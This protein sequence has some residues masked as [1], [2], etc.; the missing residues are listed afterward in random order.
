MPLDA[1][2]AEDPSL[3]ERL[4]QEQDALVR[5]SDPQPVLNTD[6]RDFVEARLDVA[7]HD[8]LIRAGGKEVN[9]GD[10]VLHPASGT[11]AVTA[12]LEIRLQ[13]RLKHRLEGSLHDPVT[14]G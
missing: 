5:D 13:D 10:R 14:D 2:T 9:L 3:E 1:L 7:L 6:M 4:D 8:P 11:E 12:R